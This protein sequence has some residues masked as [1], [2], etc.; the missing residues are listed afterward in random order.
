M[1]LFVDPKTGKT[2]ATQDSTYNQNLDTYT[3]AAA[4]APAPAAPVQTAAPIKPAA[5]ITTTDVVKA[6]APVVDAKKQQQYLDNVKNTYSKYT[7]TA[8]ANKAFL[9][10]AYTAAGGNI[11][12]QM[13]E[14]LGLQYISN[15]ADIAKIGEKNIIRL[16]KDVYSAAKMPTLQ[17]VTDS[18]GISKY[19]DGFGVQAPADTAGQA[20]GSGQTQA[21]TGKTDN[22]PDLPMTGD[23]IQDE[24][25]RMYNSDGDELDAELLKQSELDEAKN[26]AST[27]YK[28]LAVE[29]ERMKNELGLNNIKQNIAADALQREYYGGKEAIKSNLSQMAGVAASKLSSL[30]QNIK[31]AY[32]KMSSADAITNA[33]NAYN[34]SLKLNELALAQGDLELA[35]ANSKASAEAIK[36]FKTA[37]LNALSDIYQMDLQTKKF[38]Q[39]EIDKEWERMA[40]GYTYVPNPAAFEDLIKR[41]GT[42]WVQANTTKIGGKIWI[43]PDNSKKVVNTIDVG[44]QLWGLN[45]NGEKIVNYGNSGGFSFSTDDSGNVTVTNSKT[46]EVKTQYTPKP[47]EIL[48]DGSHGGQCGEYVNNLMG[49]SF[50]DSWE[51]KQGKTNVS[52]SDFASSPQVGDVL[53]MKTRMPY[54]HVAV[55]TGVQDGKVTITESNWGLD[56]KVGTRTLSAN[57][58]SI[59]GVYRGASFKQPASTQTQEPQFS[60]TAKNYAKEILAGKMTIANVPGEE[61]KNEVVNAK[62]YLEKTEKSTSDKLIIEGLNNKINDL[63]KLQTH[64]GMAGTVGPYAIARWTP[65]SPDKA[66]RGD[67]IAS[68][69]QL[70][71]KETIDTLIQSKAAGATYG[72]L[73]EGER[74]MLSR[75]ASK[76]GSWRLTE[77]VDGKEKVVGYETSEA[78]MKEELAKIRDL[79]QKAKDRIAGSSVILPPGQI[80]DDKAYQ[81][82]LNT[83]NQ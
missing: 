33:Q 46:G 47:G 23:F 6:T 3:P 57:D 29:A 13:A 64:E 45:E 24:I 40:A 36:E 53:V 51:N 55:V 62:A 30:S 11:N 2:S 38:K 74:E 28:Q 80:A 39:D 19:L 42:D 58:K 60:E 20:N 22:T 21:G 16:G 72:A 71:N 49:T 56:E 1:A 5:P 26:M 70:I 73:S 77:V 52:P 32:D 63:D 4:P 82:Y 83:I 25:R 43:K 15:P 14:S 48:P 9:E 44:G 76:I 35:T 65:F 31:E 27:R 67:F 37:R 10:G 59:T 61:M 34:Y 17:Q 78:L 68:V 41:K 8:A 50:G 69:E 81:E 7:G 66:E 79:A 75:A 54:G 18:F 12:R